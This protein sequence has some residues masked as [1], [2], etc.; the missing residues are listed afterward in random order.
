[1]KTEKRTESIVEDIIPENLPNLGM[2][3]DIQVQELQ[4][5]PKAIS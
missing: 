2:K 3:K 4:R 5:V 1:M